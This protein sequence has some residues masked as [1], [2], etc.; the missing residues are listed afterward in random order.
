M[1]SQSDQIGVY[2]SKIDV[3]LI[4]FN[5]NGIQIYILIYVYNVI[6][7]SSSSSAIDKLF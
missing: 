2:A 3:P 6:I 4:I 1:G 5:Q 7:V